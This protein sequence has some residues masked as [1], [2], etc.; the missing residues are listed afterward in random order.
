[1]NSGMDFI[2]SGKSRER[3]HEEARLT[4]IHPERLQFFG[5]L[6]EK[7]FPAYWLGLLSIGQ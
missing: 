2:T 7:Q 6:F 3:M 5:N 1:M 4:L